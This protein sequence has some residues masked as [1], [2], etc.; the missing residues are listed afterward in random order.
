MHALSPLVTI[1]IPTYNRADNYLRQA[2]TCA[3]MQTYPHLEIIVSDNGSSDHTPDYVTGLADSRIRYFRHDRNIGPNNNFNYCLQQAKGDFFVLLHDDD[4]IDQDFIETCLNAR[5]DARDIGIIRTGTR[6]IDA[7]ENVVREVPNLVKGSS[8]EDFFLS[9][10]RGKTSPYLCST[11]FHTENLRAVGGFNSPY[12][13]LQDVKAEVQLAA[14]FGRI[15]VQ[16]IK[17][18]FRR[19]ELELTR[20]TSVS[21]WCRESLLLLD[22]MCELVPNNRHVVYPEARRFFANLCYRRAASVHTPLKRFGCYARVFQAFRFRHP[23]PPLYR[24]L[25]RNRASQRILKASRLLKNSLTTAKKRVS[26]F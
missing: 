9:W 24:M 21:D 2:L 17:A 11:L 22:L 13:L 20:M 23:P 16:D 1:A 8:T 19:H 6:V 25:F 3:L 5:E 4:L 12:N 7:K 10:F 14:M 18:S 15:D 26:A